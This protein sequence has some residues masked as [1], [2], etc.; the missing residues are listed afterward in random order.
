M[1]QLVGEGDLRA[2]HATNRP[3]D[4]DPRIDAVLVT[5]GTGFIGGAV[6]AELATTPLWPDTLIMVRA[7]TVAEGRE[8][9]VRSLQRFFPERNIKGIIGDDQIVLASL[10]EASDLMVDERIR[11]VSHVIHAAAVTSFSASPKIKAINV[12]ASLE[13]LRGLVASAP[14]ER[15]VNVGTAWCAGL[16]SS[17][18]IHEAADL[19]DGEHVVPYTQSKLEFE[20][21]ARGE[22]PQLQFVT[23]RP[24]IVIGHTRLGTKPSGSIYWVFRSA[25]L[26][27]QYTCALS[28]RIDVVPV[29]WVARALVRLA[30]K[31]RLRFD[32]YHLSAGQ[33]SAC[34]FA[35]LDAAIARGTGAVPAGRRGY[36]RIDEAELSKAVRA[37]RHLLGDANPGL[38]A[39]ALR[40]YGKFASSGTIFDNTRLLSEGIPPSPPFSTYASL[41][42]ATA[43]GTSLS[44]QMED[45]FK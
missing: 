30:T 44:A 11:R 40:I 14:L 25:L 36:R 21:R 28:D 34:N 7:T 26:I 3:L 24:S 33:T 18:E 27:G 45:D 6:L 39:R 22:F 10:E 20:R 8:R 16:G 19:P 1:Q 17:T 38:L 12:D 29:D 23:G 5:G 31:R 15:F 4:L 13:F 41:C 43:R 42:A 9:V 35:L 37:K 2:R 32:A